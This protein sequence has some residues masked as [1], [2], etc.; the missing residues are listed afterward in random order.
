MGWLLDGVYGAGLIAVSPWLLARSHRRRLLP[1]RILGRGIPTRPEGI[2]VWFHGVS[3]G[4]VIILETLLKAFRQARPDV[5]AIVSTSTDTGMSEALKRH[6]DFQ[7]FPFPFDF[8]ST[9]SYALDRL[10]PDLIVL[11]ESELWPNFLNAVH[12]RGIPLAVINARMSPRSLRRWKWAKGLAN[13]LFPKVSAWATQ[14]PEHARSLV[15]LGVDPERV[16]VTGSVKFDHASQSSQSAKVQEL[17][18]WLDL[19][20]GELLWVAGSTQPG[21]EKLCLD[22]FDALHREFPALRLAIVPR[23]ASRGGEIANLAR[24]RGF[25]THQRSQND[26]T[27]KEKPVFVVDTIGE[28][29][30]LWNLASFALVGGSFDGKRGGQNMIEPAAQGLVGIFGPHVWNFQAIAK[31]LVEGGLA[32]MVRDPANLAA[33]MH[34]QLADPQKRA[35]RG[36]KA[37]AFVASQQG[38]TRRT[39]AMLEGLLPPPLTATLG[40]AAS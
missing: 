15:E 20:E 11:A 37:K 9:V 31:A 16:Q 10:Q 25:T 24:A 27:K 28:L 34:A 32:D 17:R 12:R 33:V 18:N 38:A 36:A 19:A 4:E 40:A 5:H 3:V 30:A 2:V 6:A 1:A 23:D 21:E 7:P 39:V 8:S 29:A 22:A 14:Q 26:S 35:Q 13:W